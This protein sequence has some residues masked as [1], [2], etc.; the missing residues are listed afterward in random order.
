ML[1]NQ[2]IQE[3]QVVQVAVVMVTII[4]V[5]LY[6]ALRILAEEEVVLQ[7]RPETLVVVDQV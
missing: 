6:L 5:L 2:D 4:L 7:E 3:A 1:V